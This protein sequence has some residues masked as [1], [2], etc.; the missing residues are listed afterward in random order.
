MNT[1]S[2]RIALITRLVE[3]VPGL[4]R[5]ALMKYCYFLQTLRRVPLGYSFTLYS[6]HLLEQTQRR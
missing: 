3:K 1:E 5:T 2:N 6:L 4:G